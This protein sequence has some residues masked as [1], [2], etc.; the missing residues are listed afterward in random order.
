MRHER[1]MSDED[2]EAPATGGAFD[3]EF[4]FIAAAVA[5]PSD[6]M[7][8]EESLAEL[9]DALST[10]SQAVGCARAAVALLSY[11]ASTS[12]KMRKLRRRAISILIH[13]AQGMSAPWPLDIVLCIPTS[14]MP[15]F[16]LCECGVERQW[17][18]L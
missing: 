4:P 9:R 2:F 18:L 15:P 12:I 10:F 17:V 3:S 13:M 16:I 11:P 7:R 8:V 6:N 5:S 1:G 14:L